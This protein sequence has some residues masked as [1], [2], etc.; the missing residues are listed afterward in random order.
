MKSYVALFICLCSLTVGGAAARA[1][2]APPPQRPRLRRASAPAPPPPAPP[3]DPEH[4]GQPINIR[5]DVSVIDQTAQGAA[6]PKTLMVMLADRAMG[7]TRA[8]FEDRSVSVDAR[9]TIVDG[10]HSRESH[11]TERAARRN[12]VGAGL[13]EQD[14]TLNW[15]TRSR[16]CS[17]TANRWWRWRRRTRSRS[18]RC[19]LK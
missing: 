4:G 13:N 3:V 8:A 2:Q 6:Q 7:R 10:P 17:R 18:G 16:C 11:D 5:L 19:L 1:H 14:H 15:R 9:P 12:S